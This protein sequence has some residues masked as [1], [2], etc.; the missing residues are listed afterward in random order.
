MDQIRVIAQDVGGGFGLKNS[1]TRED[2]AI[3]A[4]AKDLGRPVKW[5]EDRLEHLATG[6]QA[7]EE[8]ADLEAAV[9]ADGVHSRCSHGHQGQHR[10]LPE[11]SLPRRHSVLHDHHVVPGPDPAAGAR[12]PV[13]RA[14]QQQGHLR[15]LPGAVGDRGLFARATAR[16]RRQRARHRPARRP[17]A[18][19]RGARRAPAGHADRAALRRGDDT[20]VGGAGGPPDRL[21]GIP[22]A[23]T[24][25]SRRG[26]VPRHRHG[27][28]PRGGARTPGA[29]ERGPR[30]HGQRDDVPLRR[31][32]RQDR[33]RHSPAAP[34]PGPRDDARPGRG[35]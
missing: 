22:A 10:R 28:V 11:R 31:R 25:R 13:G 1:V 12:R 29:R 33:H 34:R 35:R 21:G 4:A 5:I 2:V 30:H 24:S 19:L 17:T 26:P 32:R 6:G 9:T 20:G 7:R 16:H 15:V 23:P 8:M 3:V 14:V 18:Q 27:L